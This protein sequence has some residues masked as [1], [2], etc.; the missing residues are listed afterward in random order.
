MSAYV[1]GKTGAGQASPAIS[2]VVPYFQSAAHIEA[3]LHALQAQDAVRGGYELLFI[4]NGSQDGSSEIVSR[5]ERVAHLREATPGAYAARNAGI[6]AARGDL[7]ALTDADCTVA[8][9]WL[10]TL[11]RAFEE[12]DV[13]A[14]I[15]HCSY[16]PEASFAL[17]VLGA[18]ENEKARHVLRDKPAAYRFAYAN[19]M[20]VRTALFHELGPFEEWKR[21]GDS[22]FVHRMARKRP[23]LQL[24]FE[25]A[26]RIVHREFLSARARARRLS[27][28]TGTNARIDSFR[29]LGRLERL[30]LLARALVRRD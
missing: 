30:K 11:Q 20:A 2:V 5:F 8:P 24:C 28:Y 12:P 17:R 21:A 6:R 25:P 9:D 10:A 27:V 1:F 13:G 22:E 18:Y 19:N 16:P 7:I 29:E 15:G 4:D 26:M 23:D 14:V 3:C